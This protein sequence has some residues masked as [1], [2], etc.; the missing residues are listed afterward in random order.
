MTHSE[1]ILYEIILEVVFML[2]KKA[3][4]LSEVVD[5]YQ[6]VKVEELEKIVHK[7]LV[8]DW[9]KE[10]NTPVKVSL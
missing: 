3:G 4:I 8:R 6:E 5:F 7:C 9:L 1:A 10:K 2:E